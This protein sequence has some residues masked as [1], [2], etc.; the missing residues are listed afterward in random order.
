M[1]AYFFSAYPRR[2]RMFIMGAYLL[3]RAIGSLGIGLSGLCIFRETRGAR[4]CTLMGAYCVS[5]FQRFVFFVG[6]KRPILTPPA[7]HVINFLIG[8]NAASVK[9]ERERGRRATLNPGS[10]NRNSSRS[11]LRGSPLVDVSS[12]IPTVYGA[13]EKRSRALA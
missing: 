11:N 3:C 7:L 13:E 6:S 5:W 4:E 2:P 1:A 9:S 12:R 10:E 8:E